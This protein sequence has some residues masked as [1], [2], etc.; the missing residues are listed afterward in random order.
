M[1]KISRALPRGGP[2]PIAKVSE[3]NDPKPLSQVEKNRIFRFFSTANKD[4]V[5]VGVGAGGERSTYFS[6]APSAPILLNRN[7]KLKLKLYD[8][9]LLLF[10]SLWSLCDNV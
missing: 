6:S 3:K 7:S 8:F 4:F 9:F 10:L 5:P 2:T 1:P